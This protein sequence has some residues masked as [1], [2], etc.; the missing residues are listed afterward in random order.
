MLVVQAIKFNYP[1]PLDLPAPPPTDG[2]TAVILAYDRIEMLF[3][4]IQSVSKAPSLAKVLVVWNNVK[5]IPPPSEEWP[6]IR[7]K[8]QVIRSKENKLSNRF[9]PY[10]EIQTACI[11]AVDDDIA[12]IT[13]DELEFGYKAWQE[14]PNRLVGFPGRVHVKD[15]KTQRWRYESEWLN[16]ISLVLT[17]AAFYHKFYHYQYTHM[18]P[19]AIRQ[20]VDVHMNC[21]DIAMNYL[22]AN[23]SGLPP[24]KVR[25]QTNSDL[26]R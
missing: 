26:F 23:Y 9:Y 14:F 24:M 6:R 16:N 11:L 21:E 10:P 1:L 20:W 12:M 18:M 19:R 17:G 4:V 13:A 3:K 15:Y 8:I 2:F 22:I 5:K 25:G 7:Q